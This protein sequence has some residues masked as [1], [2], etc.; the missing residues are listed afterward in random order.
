MSGFFSKVKKGMGMGA[1]PDV[2]EDAEKEYVEIETDVSEEKAQIT[3]RPYNIEDFSDIK[4]ILKGLREG[5]TIALVNI[6]PIKE[7][8]VIELKRSINKLKKTC[9]AI[10][11]DIAD[12]GDDYI[13]C[14]PS[15]A[16]IYRAP[17]VKKAD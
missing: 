2:F 4:D 3:V 12:F 15:F 6:K 16:K 8:D 14:T 17:K 13:V 7:K 5:Y 1:E 11:G 10:D 9:D